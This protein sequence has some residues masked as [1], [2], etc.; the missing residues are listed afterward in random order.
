VKRFATLAL[1]ALAGCSAIDTPG[2]SR[3]LYL[4]APTPPPAVAAPAG[5]PTLRVRSFAVD[6]G[7]GGF[8]LVWRQ[9]GAW[10][11]DAYHGWLSRPGDMLADASITWL[12]ASGCFSRVQRDGLSLPTDRT[13]EATVMRLC[14]DLDASPPCATISMR[15]FLSGGSEPLI[16]P[17]QASEPMKSSSAESAVEAWNAALA[18]CLT[19]LTDAVKAQRPATPSG[20]TGTAVPSAK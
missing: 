9:G 20:T 18:K 5:A 19:T 10:K 15:F 3:P 4:V 7:F 14:A 11:T 1:V 16:V 17:A 6:A 12:A 8:D 2:T 13:L